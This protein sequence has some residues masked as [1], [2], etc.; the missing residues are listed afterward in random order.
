MKHCL[1]IEIKKKNSLTYNIEKEIG[2]KDY[3]DL[4]HYSYILDHKRKKE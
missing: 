2:Y 1:N 3:F 4:Y